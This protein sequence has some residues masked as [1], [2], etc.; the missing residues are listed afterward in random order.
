MPSCK[1]IILQKDGFHGNCGHPEAHGEP[2]ILNEGE[3]CVLRMPVL[4]SMQISRD[5][6]EE[7]REYGYPAE[8]AIKKLLAIASQAS[9]TA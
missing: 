4:T 2:C 1:F 7:L 6:L 9:Q 5:T 8:K 3:E